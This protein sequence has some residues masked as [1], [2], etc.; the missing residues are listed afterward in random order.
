MNTFIN[1]IDAIILTS[2]TYTSNNNYIIKHICCS[3]QSKDNFFKS[4]F[5]QNKSKKNIMHKNIS[6]T[7][8]QETISENN[9]CFN[10]SQVSQFDLDVD[11]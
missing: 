9:V 2:E 8:T 1:E 11:Y 7:S 10:L 5:Y 4:R 6:Y 3:P